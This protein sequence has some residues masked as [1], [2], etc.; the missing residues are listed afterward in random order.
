[1]SA[2]KTGKTETSPVDCTNVSSPILILYCTY[3]KYC[4][5]KKLGKGC[6]EPPST[7]LQLCMNLY[8]KRKI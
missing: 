6:M 5:W 7:F 2:C 8:L 4:H 3:E 1:M